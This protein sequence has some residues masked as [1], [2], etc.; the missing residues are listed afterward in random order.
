MRETPI[1]YGHSVVEHRYGGAW[2]PRNVNIYGCYV[3]LLCGREMAD[4]ILMSLP[5]RMTATTIMMEVQV[6]TAYILFYKNG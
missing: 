1:G 5:R 4:E 3:M 6:S 2:I